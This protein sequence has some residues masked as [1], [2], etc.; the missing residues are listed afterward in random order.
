MVIS[1][2]RMGSTNVLAHH[3]E[4]PDSG[5]DSGQNYFEN[6]LTIATSLLKDY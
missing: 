6:I 1:L 3:K 4:D 2:H 5:Q